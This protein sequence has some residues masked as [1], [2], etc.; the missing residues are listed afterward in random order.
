M[1]LTDYDGLTAAIARHVNKTNLTSVIPDF[2]ALGEALLRRRLRIETQ[3]EVLEAEIEDETFALP[4]SYRDITSLTV[5]GNAVNYLTP[6]DIDAY[7][8][9]EGV[10]QFY[11][12]QDRTLIFRPSP[13]AAYDMTLRYRGSGVCTLSSSVKTD[14]LQCNHPDARFYAALVASAE[15]LRDD[16]RIPVWERRLNEIV[17]EINADKTRPPAKLRADELSALADRRTTDW[18]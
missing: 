8:D 3:E 12:V 10:P 11:T 5:D 14:W 7:S 17:A 18:E 9:G 16:E 6:E 1:A 4:A 15:Y 2:V 13:D